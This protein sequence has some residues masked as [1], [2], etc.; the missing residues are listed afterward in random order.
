MTEQKEIN[1][2]NLFWHPINL[3]STSL[4]NDGILKSLIFL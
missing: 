4:E 2:N 1:L 3:K